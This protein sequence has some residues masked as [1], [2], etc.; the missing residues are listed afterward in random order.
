[1]SILSTAN[2]GTS[3]AVLPKGRSSTENS[4]SKVAVLLVNYGCNTA[5]NV[6]VQYFLANNIFNKLFIRGRFDNITPLP[7]FNVV[8]AG[9][10][11]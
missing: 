5:N 11:I 1:M 9:F 10:N 7:F 3:V 6:N 8:A 2:S 4:V